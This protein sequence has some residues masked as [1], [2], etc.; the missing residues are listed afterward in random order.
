MPLP[1]VVG[2][3]KAKNSATVVWVMKTLTSKLGG[4]AHVNRRIDCCKFG[5]EDAVSHFGR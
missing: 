2:A 1:I 3:R 4:L 5:R